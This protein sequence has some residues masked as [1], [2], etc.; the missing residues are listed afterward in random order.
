MTF[1]RKKV[2]YDKFF[3]YILGF[4]IFLILEQIFNIFWLPLKLFAI[5]SIS[6]KQMEIPPFL[7]SLILYL[8]CLLCFIAEIY[9]LMLHGTCWHTVSFYF[10][11]LHTQPSS[12][13]NLH[14]GFWNL[15]WDKC[16]HVFLC[17]PFSWH[18]TKYH[19]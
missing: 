6:L 11:Y 15:F 19:L 12:S 4:Q 5:F 13:F 14:Y 18:I 17:I 1:L 10:V 3:N 7:W 9:S 8:F 2:K 16:V